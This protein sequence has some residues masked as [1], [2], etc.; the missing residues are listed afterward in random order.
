M[1]VLVVLT[2]TEMDGKT[3]MIAIQ[4]TILNGMIQTWMDME[5]TLM[6]VS[7]NSET[8]LRIC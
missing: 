4:M 1:E 6:T 8:L 2:E 7:Q 5:T 3:R